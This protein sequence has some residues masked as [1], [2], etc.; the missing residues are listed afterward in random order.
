M[1]QLNGTIGGTYTPPLSF[2]VRKT[3]ENT[4]NRCTAN[5]TSL[6][7][8]FTADAGN[9]DYYFIATD[10]TVPP[11]VVDS[12]NIE[13]GVSNVN[14]GVAQ[15]SFDAVLDQPTCK[16]DGTYNPAVLHLTNIVGATR[17]KI[18]YNTVTM[19]CAPCTDS[20]G[21]ISGS[22]LD[23]TLTT[24]SIPTSSGVLIRLY[25]DS[26]CTVYKEWFGTIVTPSCAGTGTPEF[27]AEI[28]QP[29][30]SQHTGGAIQNGYVTLKNIY[31]ATR[32]K[33]CYSST[34]NCEST[35]SSSDG[36]ITAGQDIT[37]PIQ[38]PP[39]GSSQ[40]S[41]LR[42]YNGN[43]CTVFLDVPI[44]QYTSGCNGQL[45]V[46]NLDLQIFQT[47]SGTGF[48]KVPPCDVAA[49]TPA[50]CND[51]STYPVEYN[52]YVTPNTP[53]M[54]ENGTQVKVGTASNR[55]LP[56][57]NDVPNTYITASFKELCGN[58]PCGGAGEPGDVMPSSFYRFTW[59]MALLKS[60]YPL[61]NIFTFDVFALK[62][63]DTGFADLRN[64]ISPRVN[65]FTGV[66]IKNQLY[67]N[68]AHDAMRDPPYPGDPCNLTSCP[69]NPRIGNV[70]SDMK[71]IQYIDSTPGYR[72]IGSISYNY[73]TNKVTWT[74]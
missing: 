67:S 68:N 39:A 1:A 8:T 63:K 4:G 56:T 49:N 5:C 24:P 9:N 46:M 17:Y 53:G 52:F 72:K 15:P 59:N 6:P 45:S 47:K 19:D 22:S 71:Y 38:A 18:C 23:I 30:C 37:I 73:T 42:V 20:D 65:A 43:G 57:G 27:E 58:D 36:F 41:I 69:P 51:S 50:R 11:C 25:A 31:N 40:E 14:C 70:A 3:T 26:T 12:R 10:S 34:W 7:L 74:P 21:T 16:E 44:S 13:G 33:I 35:C 54:V 60:K 28:A 29:Y 66:T 2:V 55:V 32:Y 61:I 64:F 48:D 62:T